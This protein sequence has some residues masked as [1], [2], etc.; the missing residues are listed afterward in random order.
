MLMYCDYSL[1]YFQA[2][3]EYVF[4]LLQNGP[5]SVVFIAAGCFK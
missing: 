2:V 5:V 4:I 3:V 1:E